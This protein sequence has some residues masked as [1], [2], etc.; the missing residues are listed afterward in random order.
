[1]I[2]LSD[3]IFGNGANI[4]GGENISVLCDEYGFPY[5]KGSTFKGI[6]KEELERYLSWSQNESVNIKKLLGKE[7]DSDTENKGKIRF[8]DFTLSENVKKVVWSETNNKDDILEAMTNIRAF[9]SIEDGITKNQ[10]LRYGRCLNKGL[11]FYSD[12]ECKDGTE[13]I[14]EQVLPLIKWIGSMRNRG[15]GKVKIC[16]EE[17][18]ING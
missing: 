18:E 6:F 13:N 14:V 10:T 2:L 7:D 9:T 1:M 3:T 11:V 17:G 16:K 4:P 15:F 5:F 12:I 8:S